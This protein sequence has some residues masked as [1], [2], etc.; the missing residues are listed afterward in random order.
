MAL[1]IHNFKGF[2]VS[3]FILTVVVL[4][5]RLTILVIVDEETL[6]MDDLS[7]KG[8]STAKGKKNHHK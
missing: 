7:L 1:V 4:H 6:S 3:S 8:E 5:R 2:C